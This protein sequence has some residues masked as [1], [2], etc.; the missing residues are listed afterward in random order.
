M[1]VGVE[2]I[3]QSLIDGKFKYDTGSLEISSR[4]IDLSIQKG[5][6]VRGSFSI[7]SV[8]GAPVKGE[9]LSSC[10]RMTC[11]TPSFE[12]TEVEILFSFSVF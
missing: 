6:V 9:V 4:K 1:V 12:G 8:S 10:M 2:A 5:A 11:L 3:T 7:R